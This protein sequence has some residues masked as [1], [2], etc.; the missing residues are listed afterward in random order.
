MTFR[1]FGAGLALAAVAVTGC[2][3][4][5]DDQPDRL[6]PVR[7]E[8][9]ARRIAD[10]H[11]RRTL[12]ALPAGLRTRPAEAPFPAAACPVRD[13]KPAEGTYSVRSA[14]YVEGLRPDRFAATARALLA[15]WR[16]HG[17]RVTDSQIDARARTVFIRAGSVSDRFTVFVADNGSP[18]LTVIASSPCTRRPAPPTPR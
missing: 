18:G 13:G 6:V 7:L 15:F 4:D 9:D 16:G 17:Y 10:G 5:Q 3:T 1:T 8:T 12:E 14:Y 11:A 2:S